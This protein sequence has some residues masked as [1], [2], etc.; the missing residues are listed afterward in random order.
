V[1]PVSRLDIAIWTKKGKRLGLLA[2]LRDQLPGTYT[3]GI[4]GRAPSGEILAPGEYRLVVRAYPTAPGPPSRR[5]L[6]LKIER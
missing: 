5:V 3:F 4:T 2:R 6:Q 1:E